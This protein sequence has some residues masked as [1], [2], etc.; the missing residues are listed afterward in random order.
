[1]K[2]LVEVEEAKTLMNEA[3]EW[4]IWRWLL[5]KAM[6]RQVADRGTAA[7]DDLEEKV[8]ARWSSDL[9]KA[10]RALEGD[11]SASN[12]AAQAIDRKVTAAVKKVKQAD[13]E[14]YRARMDAE[15][16]FDEAELTLSA[17]MARE[18]ARKA[19]LAYDLREEAIRIAEAVA[20]RAA[21]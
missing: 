1:M 6:V 17:G 15:N 19:I 4:S 21:G 8:K 3:M 7:L 2:P 14:A 12:G 5:Q 9:K 10:Y 16:T 13:D 18:G 11:S 20:R